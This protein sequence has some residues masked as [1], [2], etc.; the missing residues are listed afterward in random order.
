M[1]NGII[2]KIEAIVV[3]IEK[4]CKPIEILSLLIGR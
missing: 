2:Q 4:G 1:N 3:V